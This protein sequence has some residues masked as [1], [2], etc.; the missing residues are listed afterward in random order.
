MPV[1]NAVALLMS[2]S[3]AFSATPPWNVFTPESWSWPLPFFVRPFAPLI[4]PAIETVLPFVSIVP[5]ADATLTARDESEVIVPLAC[6]VPPLKISWLL[7]P[8]RDALASAFSV[9]AVMVVLPVY[10]L[11]PRSASVPAPSFVMP[12]PE[13]LMAPPMV[14]VLAETVTAREALIVTLRVPRFRAFEPMKVKSLF[15]ACG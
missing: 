6:S 9:P 3:P 10:V 15:Q 5:D 13:P 14:S 4:T 8:P 1:P 12:K 11:L 2:S 7:A